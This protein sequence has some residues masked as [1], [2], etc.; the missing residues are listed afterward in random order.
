MSS[1]LSYIDKIVKPEPKPPRKVNFEQQK[2]RAGLLC[3]AEL[4]IAT[5]RCRRKVEAIIK[6]CRA[7]NCRF[8]DLEFDLEG[9]QARCLYGLNPDYANLPVPADVLRVTQ[10]FEEPE[11]FIDGANS[12]DIAQG[13]LG[14]C[15]FLSAVS[16]VT[17]MEGLINRICVHRDEQVGVYG[18]VFYRDSG[19]IDIIIDDLLYT[20]IPKFEE[21]WEGQQDLYHGDREKFDARARIGGKTLYFSKSKTENET[22]LPLLEKAYAKL[23]GDYQAIIGG[24]DAEAIEALTGGISTLTPIKD[25]LD[26]NKFWDELLNVNKDRLFGCAIDG[27]RASEITGLYT[28]HAYSVLEAL[29]VNGKRFVRIRNPWGK[30]EWKGPWSDGS[31]EWTNEWLKLLPDL[32]HKFGD[33]G[34]FLM[35]YKDFLRTWTTVERSRIFD[36]GWKLSSMW[37][38]VTSRTYPCAWSFGDVSFTFS[39]TADSPASIVLSQLNSRCFQEI[40]G[41]NAWSLDFVIYRKGAPS[42]EHYARSYHNWF[43][44]RSASVELNNLEAGDYVLHVRLDRTH[45]RK[46]TYYQD[47]LE[48]WDVRK[49]SKVWTQ[50]AVSKSIALNFDP[51]P[52]SEYLPAPEEFFGGED[53]TSLQEKQIALELPQP[54]TVSDSNAALSTSE[55]PNTEATKLGESSTNKNE[56]SEPGNEGKDTDPAHNSEVKPGAAISGLTNGISK[57]NS[58]DGEVG[59]QD[60]KTGKKEDKPV[61]VTI[62]QLDQTSKVIHEGFACKE[63]KM[64]PIEG[65]W[66]RCLSSACLGYNVCEKC[67]K[68]KLDVHDRTHKL[69]Y[70]QTEEDSKKLKDQLK[71]GEDNAVTL[72]LRIYTKGKSVVTIGGQL[73]HGSILSWKRKGKA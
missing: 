65:P 26:V 24:F 73:R 17:T 28:S 60:G 37:L 10:I 29:E 14:D 68:S 52:Y 59:N 36:A 12:S 6:D 31:K 30:S 9:D 70:I 54:T 71:E 8:R 19:W 51:E 57:D 33:D 3:T 61:V 34:E 18:F 35:E 1:I 23:N 38:N 46:K 63:C 72:G 47:S 55:V 42:E 16:T 45:N 49:L 2:E 32:H 48:D 53:L 11:F 40:S 13:S 5:A 20:R 43:W 66:Y 69:L 67:M 22:W 44:Q 25:I 56:K 58:G 41:Y 50:A 39:V 15:W 64:S 4:E 21:L 7:R 62:A 27:S